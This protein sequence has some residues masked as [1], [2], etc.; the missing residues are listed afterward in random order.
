MRVLLVD[1]DADLADLLS[2]ALRRE[3]YEVMVAPD[4]E[5]AVAQWKEQE[6]DVVLL[7]IGLPKLDGWEVL[8]RMR[9]QV[10]TPVIMLTARDED[11]EVVQGLDLGAD[12][13]VTKPFSA[14]QLAARMR[15]VLRRARGDSYRQPSNVITT[16][17]LVLDVQTREVAKGGKQVALTPLEF[18]LLHMLL[19]NAGRVV[20]YGRLVEHAWGYAN[21]DRSDMLKSHVSH[22]RTKLGL[23]A[24]GPGALEAVLG[25]GYRFARE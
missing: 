9:P 11:H 7:D 3:G 15:A 25:V 20:P 21:E 1:D 8:R 14:K 19:V 18:R 2:Y 6:P 13:Y 22:L 5:R 10:K 12:D 23:P 4:G 24:K 16:G 17:D